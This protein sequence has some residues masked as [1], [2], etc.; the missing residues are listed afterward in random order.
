MPMS[1]NPNIDLLLESYDYQNDR[2]LKSYFHPIAENLWQE[3]KN[4]DGDGDSGDNENKSGNNQNYG[5]VLSAHLKRT[6]KLAEEFLVQK[7]G[8]SEK[9]GHNF[10]EANLF[11]DLGK[12]HP[13]Y[14]PAIWNLP[15]RPTEE[16]RAEKRKHVA[17]GADLIE[18]ALED[19]SY[20]LNTH[21]H[22]YVIKAIQMYHHERIDGSGRYK[23]TGDK[24]G[25]ALKAICIIDAFDGDMIHRPHQPA[26]RTPEETLHRLKNDEKYHGA[27]DSDMLTQFIDFY[28]STH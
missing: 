9:A 1:K 17:R 23:L 16:E 7:L 25:N 6:S 22:I 15:H 12:I 18:D 3:I 20:A 5:Q 26:K 11:Q 2:I 4:Y 28:G 24:M 19:E 21:D 13:E 8:F 10:F 14:D 27:F